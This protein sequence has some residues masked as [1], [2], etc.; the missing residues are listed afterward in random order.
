MRQRNCRRRERRLPQNEIRGE[1]H[2]LA[3]RG[4]KTARERWIARPPLTIFVVSEPQKPT[5]WLLIRPPGTLH[6][7][8]TR[9]REEWPRPV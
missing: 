8:L 7:F 5:A 3:G 6:H 1:R 9:T 2:A 4:G